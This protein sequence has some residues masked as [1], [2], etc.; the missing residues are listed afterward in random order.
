M[1]RVHALALVTV[2]GL[3]GIAATL[4]PTPDQPALAQ[5]ATPDAS[6]T[7]EADR[8]YIADLE[9]RV[10]A[11]ATEVALLAGPEDDALIGALGGRREGFDARFGRPVA[12]PGDGTVTFR[13]DD[14]TL[15]DVTFRDARAADLRVR[16]ARGETLPL[17]VAF[18]AIATVLPGDVIIVGPPTPE[19]TPMT[20]ASD[21]LGRARASSDRTGCS[22]TV[23]NGFTVAFAFSGDG[24]V[25]AATAS[26]SPEEVITMPQ[27]TRGSRASR[28]SSAVANTSLG[29]VV[30]VNGL[31]VRVLDVDRT[32]DLGTP[33]PQDAAAIALELELRNDTRR[34]LRLDPENALLVDADNLELTAICTGPQ[35]SLIPADIAPGETVTAWVTFLAPESFTPSRFV[36]QTEGARVGFALD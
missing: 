24:T 22:A 7:A 11:L 10:S 20:L 36:L 25:T 17:D 30:S 9:A 34:P 3:A 27:P 4:T 1:N 5:D 6:A 16:P 35:P 23:A 21:A 14:Q 19:M 8:A 26:V 31:T 15:L 33:L 28:G 13:I 18:A 12:Y 29:G 2:I 32:P